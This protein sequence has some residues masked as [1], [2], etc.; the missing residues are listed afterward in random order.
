MTVSDFMI[1]LFIGSFN[2]FLVGLPKAVDFVARYRGGGMTSTESSVDSLDAEN[3][4]DN[5]EQQSSSHGTSECEG[6]ATETLPCHVAT[7][8]RLNNEKSFQWTLSNW[9]NGQSNNS[10]TILRVDL[11]SPEDI[12]L[13]TDNSSRVFNAFGTTV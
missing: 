1:S 9:G 11:A 3:D 8:D 13:D 12:S 5:Q 10:G 2:P 7:S 4:E 6:G